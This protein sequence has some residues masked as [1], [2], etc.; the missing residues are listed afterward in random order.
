M[1]IYP[2]YIIFALLIYYM[3][4]RS[5]DIRSSR[6]LHFQSTRQN[7]VRLFCPVSQLLA[8]RSLTALIPSFS[9]SSVKLSSLEVKEKENIF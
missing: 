3:H 2:G 7:I 6:Y 9:C 4:N 8:L 5:I 1:M